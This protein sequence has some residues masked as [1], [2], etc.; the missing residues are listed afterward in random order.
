MKYLMVLL[1][2]FSFIGYS[3][4]YTLKGNIKDINKESIAFANIVLQANDGDL[5]K[6][7]T[8]DEN[9]LFQFD[10]LI[11]G[12]YTL[13]VYYLGFKNF[14]QEVSLAKNLELTLITLLEDAQSLDQVEITV[15]KPTIIQ[16]ADRLIYTIENTI[17]SNEDSWNILNNTP[18]I[19]VNNDLLMVKN[20]LANVYVNDKKINL[21]ASELK[22]F[23]EGLGG[24]AIKSIEVISNPS[25]KY[26]AQ[27]SSIINIVLK[28]TLNNTYK[29]SVNGNYK[30]GKFDSYKVGTTHIYNKNK[31][32]ITSNY[33]YASNKNLIKDIEEINFFD[34]QNTIVSNWLSK[35]RY[36]QE[37]EKHNLLF[38]IDYSINSKSSITLSTLHN[39]ALNEKEDNQTD[40]TIF[41]ATNSID[42]TYIANNISDKDTKYFSYALDFIYKLK[43]DGEKITTTL[44][45]SFF[46]N[47]R[48]QNV[49]TAFFLPN[50]S[51][52]RDNKFLVNSDQEINIY[53]AQIDYTLPLKGTAKFETGLKVSK[54]ESKSDF[55]QSNFFNEA[56]I[57]DLTKSNLFLYDETNYAFYSKYEIELAKIY[58]QI[59]I[60][61]EFTDL[62]GDSE[63]IL[64][65]QSNVDDYFKLFPTLLLNYYP[66]DSNDFVL[67]YK[68]SIHRPKYHQ[69]NPFQFFFSEFSANVGNPNLQP[70]IQHNFDFT[71]LLNRKY[72]FNLFFSKQDDRAAEITFQDNNTNIINYTQ[73]NLDNYTSYGLVFTA[74]NSIT[75][76]WSLFTQLFFVNRDNDFIAVAS[77]NEVI[78]NTK[79]S[80]NLKFVNN[81][82]FL[83]DK[84]LKASITYQYVSPDIVGPTEQSRLLKTNFSIQKSFFKNKAILTFGIDDVFDTA[85][86]T[87]ITKYNNQD[88]KYFSKF[89]TNVFKL[90]FRYNFGN[91]KLRESRAKK[92]TSEDKR[93]DN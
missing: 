2:L 30:I 44:N 6:G 69:L 32:N 7:T 65:T 56:P 13:S 89:D 78:N 83:K 27:G 48:N 86:G 66:N 40:G 23:L 80:Y 11:Q 45:Y 67:S 34:N 82:L 1:L 9:G 79:F 20:N 18:S 61:G 35:T 51:F 63:S 29:G 10:F 31:I 41:N 46:D 3:Q 81:F 52:I 19:F 73:I 70:A 68:K 71:Y 47:E 5:K 90:G 92:S 26:D 14:S 54:I 43:K 12:N 88:I 93:L 39:L 33:S 17:L 72:S 64:G 62:V 87:F 24:D 49:N 28:K 8:T 85:D 75:K 25:A 22:S 38:N 58:Y 55:K 42:S 76:R 37:N 60:R 21:P 74:N 57:I 53:A 59:G 15:K 91:D 4:T 50:N 77:N 84:S 16:K 36:I